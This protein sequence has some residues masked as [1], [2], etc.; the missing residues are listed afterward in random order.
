[1][2]C[3]SDQIVLT[4]S[5]FQDAHQVGRCISLITGWSLQIYVGVSWV[6]FRLLC[7]CHCCV[8]L[9]PV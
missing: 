3:T 2:T 8:L 4:D 7:V 6:W 1:M 5:S 9:Q